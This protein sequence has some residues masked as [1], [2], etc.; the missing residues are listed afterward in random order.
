MSVILFMNG[1]TELF[2]VGL[3]CNYK[4]QTYMQYIIHLL[5]PLTSYGCRLEEI[6]EKLRAKLMVNMVK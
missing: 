1:L 4:Y 5:V 6:I 2:F 3:G